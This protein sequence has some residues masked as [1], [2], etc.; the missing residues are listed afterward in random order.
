MR[1][2]RC[3]TLTN[4]ANHSDFDDVIKFPCLYVCLVTVLFFLLVNGLSELY[5]PGHLI[6]YYV[7]VRFVY[8]QTEMANCETKA[9]EHGV[10]VLKTIMIHSTIVS[11]P[12]R[13]RSVS[14][15]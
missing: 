8:H 1:F 3:A 13:M 9:C 7:K 11:F 2:A 10:R 6:L 12:I 4:Q 5:Y 15:W 14:L